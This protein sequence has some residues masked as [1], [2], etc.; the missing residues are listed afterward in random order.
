MNKYYFKISPQ[1]AAVSVVTAISLMLLGP[2]MVHAQNKPSLQVSASLNVTGAILD[3]NG[4]PIIGATVFEKGSKTNGTVTD[5]DG[6][7]SI[8]VPSKSTVLVVSYIGYEAVEIAAGSPD[9]RHIVM[10]ENSRDLDEVVVIGYGTQKKASLTGSVAVV[11]AKTFESKGALATPMQALQGQVPGVIITR[12]SGAPG[13]EGWSMNLRGAVSVNAT[14]PLVIVDGVE[15]NDG[16][17]GLRNLNTGDI[18]SINFLK[19]ASAAIYGSKAA[20]G[21]I[22]IQTKQA[23]TGKTT[24]TY[25]GSYTYKKIGLQP[26]LMSLDQWSDALLEA[27][28]NDDI[29]SGQWVEYANMCKTYKNMY[30]DNYKS[31]NP[32]SEFP[33]ADLCFIDTDWQDLMWG[34]ASS[35]NHELAVAGGNEHTK[36]RLSLGYMYD[37]STLRWGNNSKSRYN[38]RLSMN[39]KLAER[40]T[41]ESVMAYSRE[42]QV[43]PSLINDVLSQSTPQPGLPSSTIDNKPYAWGDWRTPNWLAELGG[44]NKLNVGVLN[45]SE[46]LNWGLYKDLDLVVQLGYNRNDAIRDT[47]ENAIDWYNY[48]GDRVVWQGPTQEKSKYTKAYANT[49]FY[50][51][52]A[53]LNWHKSFNDAHNVSL[54]AGA[55]YDYT[56][57]ERT[58]NSV[59]DINDALDVPNGTGEKTLKPVKWHEAMISYF[60]RA[61]YDYKGR[62]MID[63]TLRYDG[64]S[65]FISE[66]RW[67]VFWGVSGGWR[68]SE[69]KFMR[70]LQPWINNLKLRLSYGQLG[71]QSGI[72]RYDGQQLYNIKLNQGVLMDG[73]LL[74]Y[75]DTDGKI[76]STARTWEHIHNYN[77]ALD[78]GFFNNRLNGSFDVFL[79]KNNN[80]LIEAQYSGILG[81]KAPAAN[82]GKFKAHGYEGQIEWRDRI[83][84]MNYHIGGVLTYSTNEL[85]DL[86]A[87]SV[88]SAGYKKTFQG[89]PLNSYFGYRYIGKIQTEEERQKY[90]AYYLESNTIGLQNNIRLGDNMFE[91]INDDGVINQEDIVFLGSNDPKLS[92]SFN[93]G[94]EWKGFDVSFIFQGVGS[95]TIY[96]EDPWRIPLRSIYL[97]TTTMAIGKTWSTENPNAYY[98][99]YTTTGAINNYN[100]QCST[101][102][103]EDGSYLRLKNLTIGYSLPKQLLAKTRVLTGVRIYLTGEDLWEH[104]NIKDGWDPEQGRETKK[105]G[106]YPFNRTFTAGVSLTF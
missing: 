104:S 40:V 33:V 55:Q 41:L 83:G 76:V 12:S 53:Y 91:D 80:M 43:T 20:G 44:D 16:I 67:D 71:N 62:Y 92:Y 64:S 98:P 39:S 26:D 65:K 37:G 52:S 14:D 96:R 3:S 36:Y 11:G 19:D 22:L 95:R 63:A 106:R 49:E 34:D 23:K 94:V 4:D 100:Y 75:I 32:I 82:I 21:V 29:T 88:K 102:S 74:T 77:I 5:L 47:Q 87:T 31:P 60:G 25:N 45:I 57:Y 78:F 46:K 103:V 68:I 99:R 73:K 24:V 66:N 48:A 105:M 58:E 97:N 81:D 42:H 50:M 10:K 38:I 79:K 13:E 72:G 86:G 18:E 8:K 27:L 61:S 101:W 69:E 7:F 51:A 15:F 59:M 1:K 70:S 89:Y 17:S 9:I 28:G 84:N 35:T 93:F 54:M 6:N 56:Q 2:G 30:V 90:L 85:V